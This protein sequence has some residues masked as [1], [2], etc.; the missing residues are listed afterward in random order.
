MRMLAEVATP[1]SPLSGEAQVLLER[2][3]GLLPSFHE[4]RHNYAV[5]IYRQMKTE[6]AL[7]QVSLV[8]KN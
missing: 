7:V 3:L 2:C 5:V 6:A 1:A 4:A 8:R